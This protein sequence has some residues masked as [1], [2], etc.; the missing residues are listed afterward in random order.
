MQLLAPILALL[1]PIAIEQSSKKEILEE[2]VHI[3]GEHI[4]TG[5]HRCGCKTSTHAPPSFPLPLN[6][7]EEVY[8]L[9]ILHNGSVVD[10]V[11]DDTFILLDV[12]EAELSAAGTYECRVVFTDNSTSSN[13]SMGSLTVVGMAYIRSM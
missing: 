6:R 9:Q 2:H 7:S 11:T 1:P 13:I 3:Q 12:T 10:Q 8:A 4:L 5:T